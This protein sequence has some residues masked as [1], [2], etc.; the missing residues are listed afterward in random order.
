MEESRQLPDITYLFDSIQPPDYSY[1][2]LDK[3]GLEYRFTAQYLT[4]Q[5]ADFAEYREKLFQAIRH[6][7]KRQMTWFRKEK[8]IVWLDCL[9]PK[10]LEKARALVAE[11]MGE[12]A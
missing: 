9:D 5:F 2:F 8:E 1:E 4:G 7:A 3:L 10:C 11:F 12:Q 6:F